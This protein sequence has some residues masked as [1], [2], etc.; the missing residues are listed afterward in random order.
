[1]DNQKDERL[2]NIYG[3]SYK[4]SSWVLYVCVIGVAS[5]FAIGWLLH[6]IVMP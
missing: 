6:G 3:D 4:E 2:R 1:M 5:S